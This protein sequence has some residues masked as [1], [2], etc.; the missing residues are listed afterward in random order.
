[1]KKFILSIAASLLLLSGC[2]TKKSEVTISQ[3]YP[4]EGRYS[5]TNVIT[6]NGNEAKVKEQD[7]VVLPGDFSWGTNRYTIFW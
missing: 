7:L 3:V 2:V 6:I 1:M 5:S 4:F